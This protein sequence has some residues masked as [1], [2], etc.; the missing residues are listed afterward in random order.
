MDSLLRDE[1]ILE[2]ARGV[3]R[4]KAIRCATVSRE[5]IN[6]YLGEHGWVK[7]ENLVYVAYH[8]WGLVRGN[9]QDDD[10]I[11]VLVPRHSSYNDYGVRVSELILTL[12]QCQ[13]RAPV[14]VLLDLLGT[15]DPALIETE[16][17][18]EGKL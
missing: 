10:Y 11:E 3:D 12:A 17:P 16:V 15:N 8:L 14:D 6:K 18:K 2:V 5:Q 13:E 9:A 7:N 4:L 1:L